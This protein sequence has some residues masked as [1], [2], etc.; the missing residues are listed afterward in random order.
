MKIGKLLGAF[1]KKAIKGSGLPKAQLPG[2]AKRAVVPSSM[3]STR[4]KDIARNDSMMQGL[5][6]RRKTP[7]GGVI[8]TGYQRTVPKASR[9]KKPGLMKK[10]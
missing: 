10:G 1:K 2:A 7:Q 5:A 3:I 6:T 4:S 8:T 9:S